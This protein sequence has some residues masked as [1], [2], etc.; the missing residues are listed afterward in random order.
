M[1]TTHA[2]EATGTD[3]VMARRGLILAVTCAGMFLILLDVTAV[4]VALPTIARTLSTGVDGLQWVVDGYAVTIA[5][6]LLAGGSVGD[7]IGHRRVVLSGL[8]LFGLASA[9][10]GAAPGIGLLVA[11]RVLQGAGAAVLLPGTLAIITAC[12]PKRVEQA[13]AIG[14]WAAASSLALPAG[15]L[16]GGALVGALGWRAV[17]WVNLPIV[18]AAIVGTR[19]LVP[20][21]PG[22]DRRLDVP[23]VVGMTITLASAVFAVVE[24]GRY[25]LDNVVLAAA[26][27]AAVAVVFTVIVERRAATPLLPPAVLR[28]PAFFGPNL[29]A[30]SMNLVFNG[31]LFVATLFL[32]Q[33]RHHSPFAAGLLVLPMAVPL[34]ALAPVTSRLT[35][36]LGPRLPVSVGA[37]IATIGATLLALQRVHGSLLPLEAALLVLGCGAGLVTASVVAAAVR[38]V[39]VERAGFASGMNNTAR[40]SGTA[41]GV[42][43]FGAIAGSTDRID[44]FV[45]QINLLGLVGATLWALACVLAI[46]TIPKLGTT[47]SAQPEE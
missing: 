19:W 35:G 29:V 16:V 25:G 15:P 44:H 34:V 41:L 11:G 31:T 30:F 26:A 40:Q 8:A 23:G 2:V 47:Q 13:H 39:P 5:S 27:L 38:A 14:L 21:L 32:Q 17:F 28:R 1:A 6:L 20:A 45:R 24:A 4:N 18:A 37:A 3:V 43:I 33:V 36:R 22:Q 46:V 42:A 10:C 7:R 12:F 9:L